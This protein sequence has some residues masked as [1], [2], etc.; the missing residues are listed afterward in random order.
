MIPY[1]EVM[2]FRALQELLGNIYRH[3][4][5]TQ[6]KLMIDASDDGV[7]V[8]VEDNGKGFDEKILAT[9][10]GMGIKVIRDRVEMLGG[11]LEIHSV[12]EQGS[13]IQFLIPAPATGVFI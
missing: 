9:H 8:S 3:S 7:R 12:L 10:N 6:A 2:I 11:S 13:H 5:A 1:L 4:Q